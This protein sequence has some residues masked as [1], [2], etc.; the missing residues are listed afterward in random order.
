[1]HRLMVLQRWHGV[2]N[3][4]GF[5]SALSFIQSSFIRA[6]CI[7]PCPP[8]QR[9]AVSEVE[10]TAGWDEF[11]ASP[12]EL[13]PR[14]LAE[15]LPNEIWERLW[16]WVASRYP[17]S[18]TQ[19]FEAMRSSVAMRWMGPER[20][21]GVVAARDIKSGDVMMRVPEELML[22]PGIGVGKESLVT[23]LAETDPLIGGSPTLALALLLAHEK[24]QGDESAFAPYIAL[25]PSSFSIPFFWRANELSLLAALQQPRAHARALNSWRMVA[26]QFCYVTKGN[27]YDACPFAD[28]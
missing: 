26:K 18:E 13:P 2:K 3:V 6:H 4:S 11:R 22:S 5:S 1:M 10:L 15:A 24:L 7:E 12:Q 14:P 23:W 16:S 19:A 17:A 20:G 21:H 25:L 27:E 8:S 28:S 9:P